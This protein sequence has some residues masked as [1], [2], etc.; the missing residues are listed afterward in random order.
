MAVVLV[1]DDDT[2]QAKL[3]EESLTQRGHKV[4]LAAN[5][6][7]AI[8]AGMRL[9]PDVL[10]TDWLLGNPPNGIQVSDY[11]RAIRVETQAILI[12]GF[13]SQDLRQT[14]LDAGFFGYFT[15]PVDIDKLAGAVEQAVTSPTRPATHTVAVLEHDDTGKLLFANK[16]ALELLHLPGELGAQH[17]M[18]LLFTKRSLQ[19]L[20]SHRFDWATLVT[21]GANPVNV[22]TFSIYVGGGKQLL[23]L[24]ADPAQKTDPGVRALIEAGTSSLRSQAFRAPKKRIL[25]IDGDTLQ[26]HLTTRHIQSLGYQVHAAESCERGKQLLAA[27]S[28]IGCVIIDYGAQ[29]QPVAEI[30]RGLIDYRPDI[31]IVGTSTGLRKREFAAMGVSDFL[32][33]P[34]TAKAVNDVL[35]P[36]ERVASSELETAAPGEKKPTSAKAAT[37]QHTRPAR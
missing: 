36:T 1:V 22:E 6:R 11:V 13:P 8:E 24:L 7:R 20:T 17:K 26:R 10:I 5:G 18:D 28:E 16:G 19:A 33:K 21:A 27:D 35:N 29:P 37:P 30:V 14:A 31:R 34:V 3:L 2:T 12:T 9:R 15:K 4:T 23:I 32:V 25:L